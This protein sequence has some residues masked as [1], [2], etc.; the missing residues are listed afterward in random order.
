[1]SGKEMLLVI[2]GAVLADNLAFE[3]YLGLPAVLGQGKC[4]KKA[5][6]VGLWVAA[7]MVLAQAAFYPAAQ[8]LA[9]SSLGY[10]NELVAVAVILVIVYLGKLLLKKKLDGGVALI[11]L[12]SAVLG[13]CLNTL[14]QGA[15]FGMAMLT[16][17]GC[18]VG[19]LGAMLLF[20]GVKSRIDEKQV[21]AAF[22]GAPIYLLAAF[23][24]AMALT[25]YK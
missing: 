14:T 2:L 13:L 5:L 24:V 9:A 23:I 1:M 20:A 4:A 25:A 18:A 16:A 11:A 7:V 6:T 3:G 17:A 22:R 8:L 19:F 12:N 21:P 15:G 10:L